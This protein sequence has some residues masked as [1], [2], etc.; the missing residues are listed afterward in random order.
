MKDWIFGTFLKLFNMNEMFSFA[1]TF[2]QPLNEWDVSQVVNMNRMFDCGHSP[3]PALNPAFNQPINVWDVSQVV[4][5]HGMFSH[6]TDFNQ[7]LNE[8]DVSQGVD[9]HEMFAS[10]GIYAFNQPLMNG[11]FLKFVPR[12]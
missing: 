3:N 5:M 10:T 12:T 4:D 7:P 8:W 6:A 9:M 1:L 2:N 11:T